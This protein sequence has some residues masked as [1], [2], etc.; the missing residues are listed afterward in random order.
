MQIAHGQT[1]ECRAPSHDPIVFEQEVEHRKHSIKEHSVPEAYAATLSNAARRPTL[2]KVLECPFGDYFQFTDNVGSSNIFSTEGLELHVAGHMKEIALL[3]LQKLPTDGNEYAETIDSDQS[4]EDEVTTEAFGIAR[5]SM[6]SMLGDELSDFP[7]GDDG[8]AAESDV[9]HRDEQISEGV[10]KLHLEGSH[11]MSEL[12]LAVQDEDLDLIVN[13]AESGLDL[14]SK[15]ESG[16][17]PLHYAVERG[18]IR[19]MDA[20]L[21]HGANPHLNDDSGISPI[22]WAVIAG[23]EQATQQL[24]FES[25]ALVSANMGLRFIRK[26]RSPSLEETQKEI[27]SV[28]TWAARLGRISIATMIMERVRS[29]PGAQLQEAAASGHTDIVRLFLDYGY[30]PNHRGRDGLSAIHYAAEEGH[31]DIVK[32]LLEAGANPNTVNTHGTSPLHCAANGGQASIVSLIL[33]T[34]QVDT[35]NVTHHGWTALHHAAYMG[36]SDVVRLLLEHNPSI[37]FQVDTDG[38]TALHLAVLRRDL[39]TLRILLDTRPMMLPDNWNSTAED[40][41]HRW[42]GQP[43]LAFVKSHCCQALTGLRL[44]VTSGSIPLVKLLINLG[45]ELHSIMLPRI[46]C[47]R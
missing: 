16:Q 21:D 4:L 30:D 14:N 23:K 11:G 24:L 18:L 3:A 42:R 22:S 41:L 32:L 9:E 37:L 25:A 46:A 7:D 19:C 12:H 8:N 38:W 40:R 27:D 34:G 28:L 10:T 44:A 33:K 35:N 45:T 17:T 15:D 47:F 31:L 36:H 1:W 20:L 29:M 43:D 2:D 5:A 39:A 13:L 6:V 26:P